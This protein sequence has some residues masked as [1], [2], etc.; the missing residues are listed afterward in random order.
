MYAK[1]EGL[2]YQSTPHVKTLSLSLHASLVVFTVCWG[3]V[4]RPSPPV[5]DVVLQCNPLT[6][7]TRE[8][9]DE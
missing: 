6:L 1:H 9:S 8:I 2:L 7:W 4:V 3:P 5:P